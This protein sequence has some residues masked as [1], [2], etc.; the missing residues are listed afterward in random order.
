MLNIG[1][2]H[3]VGYPA[4]SLQLQMDCVGSGVAPAP[5]QYHHDPGCGCQ[6]GGDNPQIYDA[7]STVPPALTSDTLATTIND[8]VDAM[9]VGRTEFTPYEDGEMTKTLPWMKPGKGKNKGK[10]KDKK[11]KGAD[12]EY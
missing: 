11:N 12:N 6:S 8:L 2:Q 3:G 7:E 1:L 4:P 9:D 10:G 5:A